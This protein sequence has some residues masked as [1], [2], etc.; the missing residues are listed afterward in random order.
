MKTN[1]PISGKSSLAA[2]GL[3][4]LTMA[5]TPALADDFESGL[6]QW[7][8]SGTWGLTTSRAAS[9]GHSVT[10][11]PGAFYT[12]NS[13]TALTLAIATDLS[14]FSRPALAFQHSH[15]LESAYDF[16]RVEVSTDGGTTWQPAPLASYTGSRPE[17]RREQ[18]GLE[19]FVSAT[20]FKIRF[21]MTTDASVVMDGW[22]LDDVVIGNAP[23]P[24]VLETPAGTDIGQTHVTLRWS[25]STD[26]GFTSYIILR[27]SQPG[28]DWRGAKTVATLTDSATVEFTDIATAPKSNYYYQVMVLSSS[29]LHSLSNET[30]AATPAGMDYPFLDDGGGGP[31]FWIAASPWTLSDEDFHSPGHAWSDSPGGN[32]ADGIASQPLTL[33]APLDLTTS[34]QP[35]LTFCH[36]HVLAAGDTANVEISTNLGSSWTSLSSYGAGSLAWSQARLPL[37][38]YAGQS[39]VLLRFR[40]TTNASANADGW[41]IDDISV[42]EAP[43]EIAA[44]AVDEITSH[45]LRLTWGANTSL[46]FSHYAIHRSTSPG[47]GINSPRVAMIRDQAQT[48]FTDSGLALDTM[49]Y[50]RVYAVSP[51]GTYSADSA[52][53]ATIRTL[54]NP[55]PLA[56]NFDEN[57]LN[58]NFGS[59]TGLNAWGLSTEVKRSGAAALGSS[60]GASYAQNTNTW[61]E[62]AVDLRATEWPVLTFWDRFGL[63]SGD[64]IRLEITATGGP[65]INPYGTYESSRGE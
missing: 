7:Q 25:A 60:P 42:A 12:N 37:A 65:T 57:L 17:M 55:L 49:Y 23:E 46:P 63:N 1:N 51:Y 14:A 50:Y 52:N 47:V 26:P 16:G 19:A 27:G 28:F 30:A 31:N 45:T 64:W 54:N 53:E 5:A 41:H 29:G 15:E 43:A 22:Y 13:D 56:E 18:L 6:A 9:P 21:R 35:V 20:N 40:L 32:Y 62:T 39:S 2:S 44:P 61:A 48:Q 58:W 24:V 59:D 8:G 3:I 36:R 33:A 38:A 10:D 4:A 34:T 11:T